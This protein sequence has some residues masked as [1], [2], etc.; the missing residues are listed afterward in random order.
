MRNIFITLFILIN[1]VLVAQKTKVSSEGIRV[2]YMP[3]RQLP[4]E[5]QTFTYSVKDDPI[6]AKY[7]TSTLEG[8][9]WDSHTFGIITGW[10]R[11]KSTENPT[12]HVKIKS[13][14]C[15]IKE[16]LVGT[17]VRLADNGTNKTLFY[18][19]LKADYQLSTVVVDDKGDTVFS[20]T[21]N[22]GQLSGLYFPNNI[23]TRSTPLEFLSAHALESNLNKTYDDIMVMVR[24]KVIEDYV[25]FIRDT[26]T[27]LYGNK[28]EKI[29]FFIGYVKSKGTTY[30]DLDS[31]KQYL[32]VSMDSATA[33]TKNDRRCN[34]SSDGV[35]LNAAKAI[36]LWE[37]ALQEENN[38]PKARINLEI[39]GMI[40]VNL[41]YAYMLMDEYDKANEYFEK[42]L[43]TPGLDNVMVKQARYAQQ[44]YLPNFKRRYFANRSRLNTRK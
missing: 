37:K 7:Q 24:Q 15:Q 6:N 1:L 34:W 44:S 23:R 43:A 19:T 21:R 4:P 29:F 14:P 42:G 10:K 16:K 41:G 5:K 9:T 33:N 20:N 38:D 28:E 3:I 40:R 22:Q 2:T 36:R 13:D 26:L 39:A 17:E 18:Y 31:A 27:S 8:R 30:D 35:K 12:L 25:K 32:I 11:V